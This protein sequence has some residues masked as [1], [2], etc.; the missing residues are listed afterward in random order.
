MKSNSIKLT[1]SVALVLGIFQTAHAHTSFTVNS[2][3]GNAYA[4]ATYFATMNAGHGCEKEIDGIKTYF[5]TEKLEIEIPLAAQT[6]STRP[7]DAAWGKASV[8]KTGTSVTKLVWAKAN[9]VAPESSDSNLY[10]VNF[11]VKIPNA[12]WTT[13]TFKTTHTCHNGSAEIYQAWDDA[14]I[15][16]LYILPSRQPGWN[17]YTI[18]AGVT[19]DLSSATAPGTNFFKDALI[20]WAGDAAYS[21]NIETANRITNKLTTISPGAEIWVKY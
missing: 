17:K 5:D 13:V 21:A 18:P 6:S 15:P 16:T 9:G 19:L 20:V 3:T 8:V 2:T 14:N 7:I 1:T 11:N 10:R 4:G 12:P